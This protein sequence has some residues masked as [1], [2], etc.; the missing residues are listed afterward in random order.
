M[1][2]KAERMDLLDLDAI[3]ALLLRA[4]GHR[5]REPLTQA[6]EIYREPAFTRARSERLVLA[7]AKQ[8]GLSRP[9]INVFVDKYEL[10]AYWEAE[11]FAL[12]VD[13]WG[14]H[15]TRAA[16]ERD[17]LRIEDLKLAGIEAIRV[18]ARRLEREPEEFGRRLQK[19]LW[20]RRQELAAQRPAVVNQVG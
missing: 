8:A 18:T 10:D 5:G 20:R 3:D 7:M 15:R 17:P 6:L 1:V 11:R 13:G 16:F 4:G 2:E 12:E 14:T 19:L 9:K